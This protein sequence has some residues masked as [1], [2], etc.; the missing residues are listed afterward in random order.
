ML[1]RQR[2]P[3]VQSLNKNK[4]N[5]MGTMTTQQHVA[6]CSRD[7]SRLPHIS[8]VIMIIKR[9]IP[10]RTIA[11]TLFNSVLNKSFIV[12]VNDLY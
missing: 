4:K 9:L 8:I 6:K 7:G 11:N 1:V 12:L 3:A 5:I 10:K 2:D